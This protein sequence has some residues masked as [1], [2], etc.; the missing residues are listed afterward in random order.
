[1]TLPFYVYLF[2]NFIFPEL[3]NWVILTG[4]TAIWLILTATAF[5]LLQTPHTRKAWWQYLALLVVG[6]VGVWTFVVAYNGYQRLLYLYS[7]LPLHGVYLA[8]K[9]YRTPYQA[10]IQSCQWQFAL[11]AS[12]LVLLIVG[13]GWRLWR[14]FT[15]KL[16]L[17]PGKYYGRL[18]ISLALAAIGLCGLAVGIFLITHLYWHLIYDPQMDPFLFNEPTILELIGL[19]IVCLGGPLTLLLLSLA[20]F[21]ERRSLVRRSAT[22]ERRLP[23]MEQRASQ[24]T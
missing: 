23:A 11:A 3:Y 20:S 19:F 7:L 24:K 4:W 16:D 21:V 2:Q 17:A 8:L 6:A 12:V 5:F 15:R 13:A 1:M 9:L 18:R 10:A 22:R 14:A